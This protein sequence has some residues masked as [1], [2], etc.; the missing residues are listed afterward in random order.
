MG[1]GPKK[2]IDIIDNM[3]NC[4]G[5]IR[6]LKGHFGAEKTLLG[7]NHGQRVK[8]GSKRYPLAAAQLF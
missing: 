1:D 3:F 8:N 7:E 5:P 4:W 6:V 2:N